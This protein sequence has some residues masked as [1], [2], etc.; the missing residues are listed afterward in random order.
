MGCHEDFAMLDFIKKLKGALE[1]FGLITF[2]GAAI[3]YYVK[4]EAIKFQQIMSLREELSHNIILIVPALV[5]NLR[6]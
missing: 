4:S 5:L 1:A 2:L 6:L 3:L